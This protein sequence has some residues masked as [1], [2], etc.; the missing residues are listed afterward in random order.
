M[1][2]A[3]PIGVFTG[4]RFGAKEVQSILPPVGMKFLGAY[5]AVF[6]YIFN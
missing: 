3:S 2:D 5:E 6:S 4:A 1:N